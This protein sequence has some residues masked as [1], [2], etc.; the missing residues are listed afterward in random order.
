MSITDA[1][2]PKMLHKVVFTQSP[3]ARG[4]VQGALRKVT[5]MNHGIEKLLKEQLERL[6]CL[7]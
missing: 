1:V 5:R 6:A 4:R 2:V 7:N 3:K